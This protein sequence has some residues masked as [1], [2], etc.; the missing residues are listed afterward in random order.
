LAAVLYVMNLNML[1]NAAGGTEAP[2]LGFLL[3][4]LMGVVA[5]FAEAQ[6]KSLLLALATG[7][8]AGLLC[9]TKYVWGTAIIPAALAVFLVTPRDQR[10]RMLGACAGAFL[11]VLL[12]WMVRNTL[13]VGD[14]F[15]SFRWLESVMHSK[16]YPGNTL[17]R[18]FTTEYPSWLLFAVTSPREVLTKTLAGLDVVYAQPISAP[19]AYLGALFVAAIV[20]G[21][22]RRSFEMARYVLYG[23]YVLAVAVMLMLLPAQR[24]T[25]PIAAPATLI[26]VAFLVTM[27]ER[28][29][30]SLPDK[31]KGRYMITG[32]LVLGL[33]H[34]F[35]TLSRLGSGRPDAAVRADTIR[36]QAQQAAS[37][38]DGLVATDVPWPLSWYGDC[39]TLWLPKSPAELAKVEKEIGPVKWLLLTSF[40]RA[41]QQEEKTE[42]WA[43]MWMRA[44]QEDVVVNGFRVYKRLPGNWVLFQRTTMPRG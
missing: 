39:K 23:S 1:M 7:A 25:A 15:F 44:L 38:T 13:V 5:A 11:V 36:M 28:A 42:A 19:G 43:S 21:L 3:L 12:P 2:M 40:S 20:V 32:I 29:T 26:A 14:P 31:A 37:L 24:L 16:T 18:T 4:A 34:V 6:R 30:Q 8:L 41:T 17:Y 10:G 9:L 33:I 22:G 27:L 35:P